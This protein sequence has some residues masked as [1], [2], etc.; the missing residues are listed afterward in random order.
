MSNILLDSSVIV[1]YLRVRDKE[2]TLFKHILE[3]FDN[4][5]L[6]LIGHTELFS[7]KS[8]WERA[9]AREDLE[10]ILSEIEILPFDEDLSEEA[11]EI[12]AKHNISITDSIVAAT[13]IK[14]KL[15][16]ATLNLKDFDKIKGLKLAK[17]PKLAL[18]N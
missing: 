9:R 4:L 7:G 1:D 11:G 2:T 8:I 12:R 6:P 17:I 13:A 15:E 5:Y 14:H 18:E 10:A 3:T 16:V